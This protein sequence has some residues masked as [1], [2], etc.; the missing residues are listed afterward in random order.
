MTSHIMTRYDV[1]ENVFEYRMSDVMG[2]QSRIK[3]CGLDKSRISQ[4]A[5]QIY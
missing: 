1:T 5:S 4:T 3:A 2:F